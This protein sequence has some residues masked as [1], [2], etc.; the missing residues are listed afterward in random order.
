MGDNVIN[1]YRAGSGYGCF[2]NFSRHTVFYKG[3]KWPTSEHAFQA[4][5]FEGTDHFLN[6]LKT[7]TPGDAAKMGRNRSLPLRK[8]WE[9]VKDEIM[10]EVC[11]AKFQQHQDIQLTLIETNDAKLVEHTTNDSYWGD[12]GDGSGRNQLGITLMRV[13]ETIRNEL[14]NKN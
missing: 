6:V 5:K 7:K 9:G 10:Y 13:R 3:Q 14:V 4:M 12:G 2:S 8:D 11:L 1:F